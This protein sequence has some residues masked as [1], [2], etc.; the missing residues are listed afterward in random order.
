[1]GAAQGVRSTAWQR[2]V[3]ASLGAGVLGGGVWLW[4]AGVLLLARTQQACFEVTDG[5][6]LGFAAL[7]ALA[8]CVGAGFRGSLTS[9]VAF[10]GRVVAGFVA[11]A[12]WAALI[13]VTL[14]KL[15]GPDSK[16]ARMAEVSGAG[17][18]STIAA[19]AWLHGRRLADW[20]RSSLRGGVAL[21][22][23]LAALAFATVWPHSPTLRC[24]LGLGSACSDEAWIAYWQHNDDP[25]ALWFAKRG[26][27]TRDPQS[28]RLA[29]EV[30]WTGNGRAPLRDH[31]R[32][33]PYFQQACALADQRGC[34]LLRL[35]ELHAACDAQ[36]A[37]ACRELG[38]VLRPSGHDGE[39]REYLRRACLLG[40]DQ[41]CRPAW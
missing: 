33:E 28:C 9:D 40:D 37:S 41:A 7:L 30:Y 15:P 5:Q 17:A 20:A 22:S 10:A 34:E 26:C 29:G 4:A 35:S 13:G 39:G 2:F 36:R 38:E 1:V 16:A 12:V 32:A 19:V 3:V 24:W 8:A 31:A 14:S 25:H 6:V 21:A 11:S 23:V 18:L 27:A